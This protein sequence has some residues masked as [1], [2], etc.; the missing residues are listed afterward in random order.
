MSNICKYIGSN[1][2]LKLIPGKHVAVQLK[3][4]SK[5]VNRAYCLLLYTPYIYTYQLFIMILYCLFKI[6]ENAHLPLSKED[7][8]I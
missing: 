8:N 3:N 7:L 6:I 1:T 2:D 5:L 4:G